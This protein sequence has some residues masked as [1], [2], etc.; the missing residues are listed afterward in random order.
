MKTKIFNNIVLLIS[1]LIIIQIIP[2][3]KGIPTSNVVF[4]LSETPNDSTQNT[5][6]SGSG[7]GG[8][9]SRGSCVENWVCQDYGVC[10]NTIQERVCTDLNNCGTTANKP[11]TGKNCFIKKEKNL[12]EQAVLINKTE[13]P[14]TEEKPIITKDIKIK[15]LLYILSLIL[16]ISILFYYLKHQRNKHRER[17]KPHIKKALEIGHEPENIK[18]KLLSKEWPLSIIDHV[19]KKTERK[20]QIETIKPTIKSYLSDKYTE[21]QIKAGLKKAGWPDDII[22]SSIKEAK[23]ELYIEDLHKNLKR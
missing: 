1:L 21:D 20:Q 16:I 15:N 14:T 18:K 11:Q 3:I 4:E 6:T 9:S 12:T 23:N 10:I 2:T 17:L 7:G 22:D 19:I 13:K 8:G 5:E